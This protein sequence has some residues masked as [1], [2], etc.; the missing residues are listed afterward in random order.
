MLSSEDKSILQV[1]WIDFSRRWKRLNL[2]SFLRISGFVAL[3]CV[4]WCMSYYLISYLC[5]ALDNQKVIG[6]IVLQ[7]ILSFGFLA[8]FVVV[9]VGNILSSQA[10]L[11]RSARF[12]VFITSPYPL[13]RLFKFHTLESLI[14]GS[15]VSGVFCLP[16]LWAY[17]SRLQAVW[18]YYPIVVFGLVGLLAIAGLLGMMLML[19]IARFITGRRLRT[20][21]SIVFILGSFGFL[22]LYISHIGKMLFSKV[23]MAHLG[24]ALANMQM[25]STPYLPNHWLAELMLAARS[26][27]GLNVALYLFCFFSTSMFLWYLI[28]ELGYHFFPAAWLWS[29]ERVTLFQ[30]RGSALLF[31]K[32][33]LWINRLLPRRI[34]SVIYKEI[35]LF[36]RD[37]SQWGQLVLILTIIV[38]YISHMR[39]I[40]MLQDN[41][42]ARNQIAF[43]N[44]LLLGFLQ[45]TLALRYT[46]PS[47]SLEG[48]ASWVLFS[49]STGIRSFY[50]TKLVFHTFILLVFGQSITWALN[51]IL[52]ID[53]SM[54]A[55]CLILLFLL[56]F[57][58]AACTL[59]LGAIF[60]NFDAKSAA[61]VTSD[62]GA[63]IAMI[64][65]LLYFALSM[66]LSAKFALNFYVG[67]SIFQQYQLQAQENPTLY[68]ET[69][70]FLALQYLVIVLPTSLG[71]RKLRQMEF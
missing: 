60:H 67:K 45:A 22:I 18:W 44:V 9:T 33:I 28:N 50:L 25:A 31:N 53:P 46:F 56:S 8:A 40:R 37:F 39:N 64:L 63:L 30:H 10:S 58:F 3:L 7:R 57:G 4:F 70:A 65:T 32:R 54:N 20:A 61:D 48:R 42:V 52:E 41:E 15:W 43:F 19:L 62:T 36:L 23:D 16:I 6:H 5:G 21:A 13:Y 35:H 2:D 68:I 14:T 34:G 51:T 49:S 1:K 55:L 38:F 71:I 69:T 11:Y 29:Q 24:E 12:H 59:G 27:D 47:I 26:Q 17:G 66:Y